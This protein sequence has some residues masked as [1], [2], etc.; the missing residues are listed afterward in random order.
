MDTLS[1]FYRIFITKLPGGF[2]DFNS[3]MGKKYELQITLLMQLMAQP[4]NPVIILTKISN[5]DLCNAGEIS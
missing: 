3:V 1:I 4:V 2:P 5:Q